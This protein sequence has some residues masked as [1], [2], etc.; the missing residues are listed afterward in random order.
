VDALLLADPWA[1]RDRAL[2]LFGFAGAFR[3]TELCDAVWTDLTL[4]DE[5]LIVLLRRSK[6]DPM[7]RGRY[8]GIPYGRSIDTCPVRAMHTW[9][10]QMQ[11]TLGDRFHDG[12]PCFVPIRRAG[13]MSTDPLGA[14]SVSRIL[15]DRTRDAGIDG[16]F[17]GRSLRAGFVSTAADLGIP[18]EVIAKHTRHATMDNVLRYM[19]VDDP[20]RRN[21]ATL[22]GL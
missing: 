20:L 7:G 15:K 16:N 5:G 8:V 22:V 1:A 3:R 12:L 21:A 4:K 17:G 11:T 13:G 2:L 14:A 18:G 6:T 9:R 19:R 10:R